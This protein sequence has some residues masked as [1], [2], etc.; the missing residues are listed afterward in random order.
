MIPKTPTQKAG[1]QIGDRVVAFDYQPLV[2]LAQSWKTEGWPHR[3]GKTVEVTLVRQGK[4]VIKQVELSN[5]GD[6]VEPLLSLFISRDGREWVLWTSAGYYDASPGGDRFIGWLRDH[7][8]P[9]PAADFLAADQF[10]QQF[11]RPDVID[12]VLEEGNVARAVELADAERNRPVTPPQKLIEAIQRV[13]PPQV[14]LMQPADLL[15]TGS[16]SISVE[17]AIAC[18]P[19]QAEP[20]VRV[21]V[22]GNP[23]EVK[24]LSPA[25]P[26]ELKNARGL[27]AVQSGGNVPFQFAGYKFWKAKIKVP[28]LPGHN[29]IAVVAAGKASSSS[30]EDA[31]VSVTYRRPAEEAAN[32]Y[33]AAIG[34]SKYAKDQFNLQFADHDAQ[35]FARVCGSQQDGLYKQVNVRLLTNAEATSPKLHDVMDWLIEHATVRDTVILFLAGHGICDRQGNYY[36]ATHDMDPERLRSTCVRWSDFSQLRLDLPGCRTVMFVDTCHSGD[37][38]G[39]SRTTSDPIAD[40]SAIASAAL[41]MRPAQRGKKVWK[42]PSGATAPLPR[43][44]STLLSNFRKTDRFRSSSFSC[45]S[46]VASPTSP[47]RVSVRNSAP[48]GS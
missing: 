12:L 38:G 35:E 34:V 13:P 44:C 11:Y 45:S 46:T 47:A 1:I 27:E 6:V 8:L 28:L 14:H 16:D 29:D 10:R 31:R 32:L 48:R 36:F 5:M 42:T 33:V 26:E 41:S 24:E 21:L 7:T 22:N 20:V 25:K 39:A 18:V 43:L 9:D 17:A 40:L 37:V 19:D 15:R 4:E 3:S 30:A 2:T 23:L